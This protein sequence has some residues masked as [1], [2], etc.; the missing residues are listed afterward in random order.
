[1][2]VKVRA[3]RRGLVARRRRAPVL[4]SDAVLEHCIPP[5]RQAPVR[6]GAAKVKLVPV[7]AKEKT[8]NKAQSQR[9]EDN[10][11]HD[12]TAKRKRASTALPRTDM[13]PV[14]SLV[15]YVPPLPDLHSN[16]KSQ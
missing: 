9:Q 5:L 11:R 4:H 14:V 10:A 13:C 2:S 1:M 6:R 15:E 12:E 8:K 7:P 16:E 3:L